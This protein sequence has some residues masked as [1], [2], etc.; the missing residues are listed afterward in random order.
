MLSEQCFTCSPFSEYNSKMFCA[1]SIVYRGVYVKPRHHV[2]TEGARH[3]HV[4]SGSQQDHA[5]V[6]AL[7]GQVVHRD[8]GCLPASLGCTS[9]RNCVFLNEYEYHVQLTSPAQPAQRSYSSA[10]LCRAIQPA[11]KTIEKIIAFAR[12]LHTK[13]DASRFLGP[14]QFSWG[15]R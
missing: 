10:S 15:L 6:E 13:I 7:G 5:H 14:E 12:C 2:P 1:F 9:L 4:L 8:H 3:A 11:F